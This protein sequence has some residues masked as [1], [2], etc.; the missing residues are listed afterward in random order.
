MKVVV[1]YMVRWAG[2]TSGTDD[3][4]PSNACQ[5]LSRYFRIPRWALWWLL[6]SGSSD[7]H[8]GEE[9]MAA[10]AVAVAVAVA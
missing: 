8:G 10:T 4:H 2:S 5:A 3:R 7:R 1:G 6:I 9:D